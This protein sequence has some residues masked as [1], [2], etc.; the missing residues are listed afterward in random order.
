M[1]TEFCRRRWARA[2]ERWSARR[3]SDTIPRR[4]E[5]QRQPKARQSL[6]RSDCADRVFRIPDIQQR[7]DAGVFQFAATLEP[8]LDPGALLLAHRATTAQAD[9]AVVFT[10]DVAKAVGLDRI[11]QEG[12][13]EGIQ[14]SP[15]KPLTELEGQLETQFLELVDTEFL[16][17]TAG[18]IGSHAVSPRSN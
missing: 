4:L 2:A 14:F 16:A 5:D 13:D 15:G 18:T 11:T 12:F 1:R 17:Q 9:E 6:A 3:D 10:T 8:G 7:A